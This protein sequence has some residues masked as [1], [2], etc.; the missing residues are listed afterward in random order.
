MSKLRR[1]D[2]DEAIRLCTQILAENPYDR[3][4]DTKIYFHRTF[5]IILLC[6][7]TQAVWFLKC[8][9]LTLRDWIDDT[10]MEEEGVGDLL[11]DENAVAATPRYVT[12]TIVYLPCPMTL[13]MQF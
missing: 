4:F 11:L 9:A 13:N 8:R 1:R 5:C 12:R 7:Q 3:V 6:H 10:E 2:Y